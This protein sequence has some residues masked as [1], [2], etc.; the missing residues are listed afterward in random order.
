MS[1]LRDAQV[2]KQ[3]LD[4]LA[5]LHNLVPFLPVDRFHAILNNHPLPD[6]A[7][8]TALFADISGFTA[9]AE[10]LATELGPERGAEELNAQVN[11]T[12]VG[13]IDTVDRYH[14]SVLRFS[15]D[16]LTAWFT[17]K[18]CTLRA[19][20]A[21]LAMQAVMRAVMAV[22]PDLHLKIGIGQGLTR[23]FTP[24]DPTLGMYDVLTGPAIDQM[25]RAEKL[26][27]PG[28]I[29]ISS[30][31]TNT[32]GDTF[33]LKPT[34]DPNF[35]QIKPTIFANKPESAERWTSLR[36]LDYIDH[37]VQLVENCRPYLPPPIYE[38][39]EG[40][41]GGY[42]TDIRMVTPLFIHFTGLDYSAP[43]ADYKLDEL[44]RV[45]QSHIREQGG[46]L[47]EVEVGD[48]GSVLVGLFGAPIALEN[49]AM[50][51]AYAALILRD[52]LP[53]VE[54]L[55]FGLTSG[56]LFAGTVGSP[57]RSAYAA[58][59]DEVNLSARLMN[60]AM[61][62]EILANYT[63]HQMA[64]DFAWDALPPMRVKGKVAPVRVYR[65][66][67]LAEN[68]RPLWPAGR[69]LIRAR[70]LEALHWT[71][72]THQDDKRR[73]LVMSGEPGLGKSHLLREFDRLLRERGITALYGA[74]RNIERQTPYRAWRDVFNAYFEFD[75][76][77]TPETRGDQV[78]QR[79]TQIAPELGMQAP[80]FNDVLQINITENRFTESLE[81]AERHSALLTLMITL[82]RAWLQEDTLAIVLDNAQWLD[83]LSWDLLYRIV[84]QLPDQ[85][86]SIV[87][88]M[89]PFQGQ[90]PI[91]FRLIRELDNTRDLILTPLEPDH[92]RRLAAENLGVTDLP[93]PIAQLLMQKT[94][95]NPFFINEVAKVLVD[96]G[97]VE[98]R[99]DQAILKGD[100]GDLQMPDTVQGIVRSRIDQLPLDQQSLIKV[101]AVI[102]PQFNFRTLQAVQPLRITDKELQAN[103]DA[104]SIMDVHRTEVLH[105]DAVYT[106]R[107]D[108]TRDIAYRALSFSQRRQ[109]HQAVAQWYEHEYPDNLAPYYALL[110]HHWQSAEVDEKE[111]HYAYLSGERAAAQYANN[112]AI[113]YLTRALELTPTEQFE[114]MFNILLKLENLYH[115]NG[116]RDNQR[117][118]LEGM[119]AI[120]ED[121]DNQQWHAQTLIQWARFYESIAEYEDGIRAAQDAFA[122]AEAIGDEKLTGLASVYHGLGLMHL[123][124]Y[125]AARERLSQIHAPGNSQIEAW[126]LDILG[127]TLMRMGSYHAAQYAFHQ[128]QH[129]GNEAGDR[130]A[131]GQ[132]LHNMGESLLAL[133][134]YEDAAH[135]YNRALTIRRAIGDRQGEAATLNRL[136]DLALSTGDFELAQAYLTQTQD[137]FRSI[138][139]RAGEASALRSMG[140]LNHE[141]RDYPLAQEYLTQSLEIRQQIND[142]RGTGLTLLS[143]AQ[144][145]IEM[146]ELAAA[147]QNLDDARSISE[148]TDP[149]TQVWINFIGATLASVVALRQGQ[150]DFAIECIGTTLEMVDNR[151]V[152]NLPEFSSICLM[153]YDVLMAC[154]QPD[155]ARRV[156]DRAYRLL[157]ERADQ[158]NAP[159]RRARYLLTVPSHRQIAAIYQQIDAPAR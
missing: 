64:T 46:Y 127:L 157:N 82:L 79:L 141:R 154:D 121:T 148:H 147:R 137:V 44:V 98:I 66:T 108:I 35:W 110:T 117:A 99:D 159:E 111:R 85:P 95:G 70:E 22:L 39:L 125:D 20:T 134:E 142:Q 9:L 50:R 36:W 51:A 48:K 45:A 101:A 63:A 29:I 33:D 91:S 153:A 116:A 90:E 62:G 118:I 145:E 28:E 106:F 122:A 100:P 139:D 81:P 13:M 14:G 133:G 6:A 104:L 77:S 124:D 3:A 41:R 49:P 2:D 74:G 94:G 102:G 86:L 87:L 8:G 123:G 105:D 155:N 21:A 115:L 138:G 140:T 151:A 57:M 11:Y 32:I 52:E 96:S 55:H 40:G 132:T 78:L 30:E 114:A 24:G 131:V 113:S 17:G 23:R 146:G 126:R 7:E 56:R 75:K 67:G 136:G 68:T 158:I 25:N 38:R 80:L 19:V 97:I 88:A 61:P 93:E 10:R 5:L 1:Q 37:A 150:R 53:F 76:S 89:R 58:I 4:R 135:Y 149:I 152:T 71:I 103:L 156:I 92:A 31:V 83:A 65:L 112:D 43:D 54:T 42:M 144:N 16:G 69:F 84:Q 12:F 34:A 128:A 130:A 109:I 59:G 15:G 72:S 119:L 60:R 143:L 120:A 18:E 129:R 47:N 26:A 107:Y 27:H 73:L